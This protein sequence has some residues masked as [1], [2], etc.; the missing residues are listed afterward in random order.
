M[1]EMKL[2]VSAGKPGFPQVFAEYILTPEHCTPF[3]KLMGGRVPSR[4]AVLS[5]LCWG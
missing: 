1:I 2:G 4:L 5:F 3:W